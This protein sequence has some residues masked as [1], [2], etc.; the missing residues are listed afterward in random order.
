MLGKQLEL[1]VDGLISISTI[2]PVRKRLHYRGIFWVSDGSIPLLPVLKR[3]VHFQAPFQN[4]EGLTLRN[5]L[6]LTGTTVVCNSRFTKRFI[7]QEFGVASRIVY[8]PVAVSKFAPMKK[9]K[10]ILSVG[11]F[12]TTSQH[13]RPEILIQAFKKMVDRGL[14]QWRVCV[15]GIVENEESETMVTALRVMSRGYP[16]AIKT[17]L[18]HDRLISLFNHASIYWHAAGYGADIESHPEQ[19]EHFGI[20]TVEA[21]AAGTVPCVFA[22]GGQLEIITNGKDGIFWK[23][24]EDLINK[25]LEIIDDKEKLQALSSHAVHRAQVFSEERFCKEIQDLF[26]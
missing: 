18:P 23:T 7:D 10:L 21:M 26:L 5:Q 2:P 15:V 14:N 4:I 1:P 22:A 9:D 8:P 12:T 11:R 19:A 6:K 17:N 3:V 24:Q 25:T 20:S 13:K 16:I